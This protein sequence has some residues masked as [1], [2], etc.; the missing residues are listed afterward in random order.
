ML[1]IF[2]GILA[3]ISIIAAS[4]AIGVHFLPQIMEWFNNSIEQVYQLIPMLPAWVMP[5][6]LVAVTVAVISLGVKL[7]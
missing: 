6:I 1:S 4:V 3:G 5:Y 7:L 2:L